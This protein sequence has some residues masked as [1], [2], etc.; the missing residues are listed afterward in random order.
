MEGTKRTEQEQ[1]KDNKK[2]EV[3]I[4]HLSEEER[5]FACHL[6]T[7]ATLGLP[8]EDI[9]GEFKKLLNGTFGGVYALNI[10][11]ILKRAG[12]SDSLLTEA[13][14]LIGQVDPPE[15]MSLSLFK[16]QKKEALEILGCLHK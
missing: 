4:C 8:S 14:S 9:W 5:E 7:V 2:I 3:A 15:C 16:R 13:C 6:V 1:K 10:A 12:V 11:S